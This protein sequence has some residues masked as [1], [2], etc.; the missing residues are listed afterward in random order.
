MP[1]EPAAA[2]SGVADAT[3]YGNT[4]AQFE[5]IVIGSEDCLNLNVWVPA[6][7]S[8]SSAPLPVLVWMYGG[9]NF[10]G[11]TNF[12]LSELGLGQN[13]Y[14]GQALAD[15]QHAVVVSFNYRVG[16]LGFLANPALKAANPQGTTGNYGL[17]D[18]LLALHWVQDNIAAFGGDKTHVT[19]F[20]QSAGA[21]NTCSLIASPLAAGLFSSALMESGNCA[22]EQLPYQYDFATN[23]VAAMGCTH[24]SDVVTCLQNAPLGAFVE[25]SGADYIATYVGQLLGHIDPKHSQALPFGPTV[26]GYVLNDTPIATI[27]AGKHDHVPIVMGTNANEVSFVGDPAVLVGCTGAAALVNYWFPTIAPQ[28]LAAYPCN[29]LDPLSPAKSLGQAI[30]DAIFTCPT[31][32]AARAAAST[33]TQPVFRYEWTHVTPYVLGLAN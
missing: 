6:V 1:P 26:D 27:Q 7:P 21:F 32:R 24:A 10:A 2:W 31:R 4:C 29:V 23:I 18:A 12:G 3:H 8:A 17:L 14:D 11:G 5:G 20:G 22:A 19:L 16:V 25:L 33:Q 15:A 9:G 30:T 13:I 28:F